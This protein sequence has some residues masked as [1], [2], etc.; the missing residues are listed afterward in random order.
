LGELKRV[1]Q[2]FALEGVKEVILAGKIAK[3]ELFKGHFWPDIDMIKVLARTRDSKDDTLLGAVC[4]YLEEKG[5]HVRSSVSFLNDS[6]PGAGVLSRAMPTK[7]D[8][9]EIAFAWEMA[10]RV[11]GLDIGQTVV[12]KKKAIL[13]VEAIEGTDEAISRG[14]ALGAGGVTVVKVAKPKQDMRFDVPTIGLDTLAV[15]MRVKARILA[16]E[17][18]K[19][20]LL[21]RKEFLARSDRFGL[22]VVA[23][24]N[25]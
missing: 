12:T 21:D 9:Q 8:L 13:A 3:V 11:A 14:G 18:G 23:K 25:E 10:K 20:I 1:V 24:S 22:I 4:G 6:L 5:M 7:A 15:L 16:F 19:T 17:A 2:F